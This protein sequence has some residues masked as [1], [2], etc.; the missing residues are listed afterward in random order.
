MVRQSIDIFHKVPS[1]QRNILGDPKS[2]PHQ[3]IIEV[4]PEILDLQVSPIMNKDG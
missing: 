1:H 4:G 3:A 2:L